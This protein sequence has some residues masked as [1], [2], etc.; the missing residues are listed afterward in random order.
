MKIAT[1]PALHFGS[2]LLGSMLV[3]AAFSL[4]AVARQTN[5]REP[6]HETQRMSETPSQRAR[7][8]SA[9]EAEKIGV[10]ALTVLATFKPLIGG[11]LGQFFNPYTGVKLGSQ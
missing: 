9:L 1:R 11:M 2:T 7:L 10:G 3:G 8:L 5:V 6:V 4:A